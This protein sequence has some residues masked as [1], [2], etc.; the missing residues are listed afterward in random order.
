MINDR[1]VMSIRQPYFRHLKKKIKLSNLLCIF[2]HDCNDGENYIERAFLQVHRCFGFSSNYETDSCVV[3]NNYADGTEFR[4]RAVYII[5]NYFDQADM[6]SRKL[7]TP[8]ITDY[9]VLST[10]SYI[11]FLACCVKLEVCL[12][13]RCQAVTSCLHHHNDLLVGTNKEV[14]NDIL[15]DSQNGFLD[16]IFR[17]QILAQ[18]ALQYHNE[19]IQQVSLRTA[20]YYSIKYMLSFKMLDHGYTFCLETNFEQIREK[21]FYEIKDGNVFDR[22]SLNFI[23]LSSLHPF[24]TACACKMEFSSQYLASNHFCLCLGYQSISGKELIDMLAAHVY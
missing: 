19:N 8:T 18:H 5:D 15:W 21:G 6:M 3:G 10:L 12:C 4:F 20:H 13:Y 11:A 14:Y 2:V 9:S 17:Q 16:D 24:I 1:W 7:R 23:S 22:N